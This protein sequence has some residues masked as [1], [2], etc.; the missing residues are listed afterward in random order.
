MTLCLLSFHAIAGQQIKV[1]TFN[2]WLVVTPVGLTFSKDIDTRIELMPDKIAE[3]GA[4]IIGFQEVWNVDQRDYLIS[5]LKKRGYPFSAYSSE[6]EKRNLLEGNTYQTIGDVVKDAFDESPLNLIEAIRRKMGNGLLIVSKYKLS[7]RVDQLRF[8]DYTRG[9]EFAVIKGAIRT[10]VEIPSYG[11]VDLVNAHLGAVGE[12]LDENG[13]FYDYND[14]Q[15]AERHDQS[16]ELAQW[17][18]KLGYKDSSRRLIMTVDLNSHYNPWNPKLHS[19]DTSFSSV[20]YA[21]YAKSD[22]T[23]LP[24]W[25]PLGQRKC[26]Q[27]SF[28]SN[29]ACHPR[30]A[31]NFLDTYKTIN[32]Y[33]KT[34]F[35][36]DK[37]NNPY[38]SGGY[39]S[40]IPPE[41]IDYIFVNS[42]KY[43]HVLDSSMVFTEKLSD[44]VGQPTFLSDHYGIIT[45][46]ELE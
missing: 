17:L 1:L 7:V 14:S 27:G 43:F 32:G 23:I 40:G 28:T 3:T 18:N 13:R 31:F 4:D 16:Y 46:L 30:I 29:D 42:S 26:P 25:N 12:Q 45:T 8:S 35:S 9:D 19:Y 21:T 41:F 34:D 10:Q 38:A 33:T 20:E 11:W 15:I 2:A 44:T 36:F 6:T 37:K 24:I 39:F 22:S 5:E